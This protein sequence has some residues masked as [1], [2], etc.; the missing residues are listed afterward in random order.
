MPH[1]AVTG[2]NDFVDRHPIVYLPGNGFDIVAI[3]F[4][5]NDFSWQDFGN[6]N[7]SGTVEVVAAARACGLRR[8]VHC[9]TAGVATNVEGEQVAAAEADEHGISQSIVQPTQIYGPGNRFKLKF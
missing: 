9:S 7:V 2:A 3:V 6:P 8:I 4:N 5:R 1:V